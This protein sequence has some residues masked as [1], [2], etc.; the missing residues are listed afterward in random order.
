MS[1]N[2]NMLEESPR[3]DCSFNDNPLP[4]QEYSLLPHSTINDSLSSHESIKRAS[5]RRI[6]WKHRILL[7]LSMLLLLICLTYLTWMWWW[8]G[9][10]NTGISEDTTGSFLGVSSWRAL[11]SSS[12]AALSVTLAAVAI[13]IASGFMATLAA[14]MIAALVLETGKGIPL[15]QIVEVSTARFANGGMGT[16]GGFAFMWG[17]VSWWVWLLSALLALSTLALQFSSTLLLSDFGTVNITTTERS[18][19]N[20]FQV[21]LEF[22]N[23][24]ELGVSTP[25]PIQTIN[26]WGVNPTTHQRFIEYAAAPENKSDEIDTTGPVVRAFLPFADTNERSS[27]TRFH[28]MA[29]VMDA[30]VTCVRP[31][32]MRPWTSGCQDLNPRENGLVSLCFN[33]TIEKDVLA[34]VL[35]DIDTDALAI[36]DDTVSPDH[37]QF[38]N[39]CEMIEADRIW[40]WALCRTNVAGL[41]SPSFNAVGGDEL[42][43]W[44]VWNAGGFRISGSDYPIDVDPLKTISKE[45]NGP[46]I[47]QRSRSN[48]IH[49]NGEATEIEIK[50]SLCFK[51]AR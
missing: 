4:P 22:G 30:S 33:I 8:I 26:Y 17:T 38:M 28:G 42:K 13:R 9:L 43:S 36:N 3:W 23:I 12:S 35:G 10:E 39:H 49:L 37:V 27:V 21:P 15:A 50:A 25:Y 47:I 46:W 34:K 6:G 19:D 40:D 48:E 2:R 44:L 24:H 11:I 29:R 41:M 20:A 1:R 5:P 14:S 31:F 45:Y 7:F 18:L 51:T 16:L 32:D